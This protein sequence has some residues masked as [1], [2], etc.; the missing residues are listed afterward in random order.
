MAAAAESARRAAA[1]GG[2]CCFSPVPGGGSTRRRWLPPGPAARDGRAA[3]L[4]ERR[5][6]LPATCAPI[7]RRAGRGRLVTV[8]MAP[9]RARA[10]AEAGAGDAR[11]P[12]GGG[13]GG[14]G[15]EVG[16]WAAPR[17]T[18]HRAS[19]LS[20]DPE[21]TPESP[22]ARDESGRGDPTLPPARPP[23]P[24]SKLGRNLSAS[25]P[26]PATGDPGGSLPGS[27]C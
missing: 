17:G 23:A 1:N 4:E 20:P 25:S 15:K 22:G 11:D 24:V 10:G 18:V 5:P 12:G 2:N 7:G 13:G 19:P 3:I 21:D 8:S 16:T 27:P 9:A 14:G 26:A 6:R